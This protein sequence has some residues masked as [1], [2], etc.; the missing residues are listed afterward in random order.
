MERLYLRCVDAFNG[1]E[2][3]KIQ[4]WASGIAADGY[5]VANNHY[6]NMITAMVKVKQ[7]PYQ[8]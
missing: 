7:L 1:N 6:N 2:R 4:H 8:S 5:L 3:V